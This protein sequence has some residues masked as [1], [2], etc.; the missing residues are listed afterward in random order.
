MKADATKIRR[1]AGDK[2]IVG[3]AGP[4]PTPSPSSSGSRPS[5]RT[6]L[7]TCP[8]ATELAKEW[9][10][11]RALRRLEAMMAVVDAGT[12]SWSPAPAT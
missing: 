10:T 5:S 7:A 6:S 8:G 2:V 9:R 12:R 1:L 11:D 4:A 3:F